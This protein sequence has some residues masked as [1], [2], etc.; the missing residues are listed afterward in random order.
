MQE[1]FDAERRVVR[2][3]KESIPTARAVGM[4]R[5]RTGKDY[6]A[7]PVGGPDSAAGACCF[8]PRL[9]ASFSLKVSRT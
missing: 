2:N 4:D 1:C 9:P 6:D 8:A 7:G 5:T 3:G